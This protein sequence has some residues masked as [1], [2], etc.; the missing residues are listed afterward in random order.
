RRG[1]L[2]RVQLLRVSDEQHLLA[3]A[4]HHIITDGWSTGVLLEDLVV[5]YQAAAAGQ[6]S[7][8]PDLAVQYADF[9]VWQRGWLQGEVLERQI[10][11]WREQLAG[12]PALLELPTDFP[13]PAAQSF[14]GAM[15]QGTLPSELAEA[16][17]ELSRAEGTTLFM[18]LLAGYQALLARYSGQSDILVGVPIA[19]RLRPELASLIGFFVNT[20]VMRASLAEQ[21]TVRDLLAQVRHVALDAYAHQ[22]IPFEQLVEVLQPERTLSHTPIFQAAFTL[23][24]TP[25]PSVE[26]ADL[27]VSAMEEGDL[28]VAKFD[29]MLSV[30]E[31]AD[32]ELA[33]VVEYSTD[34][35][36]EATIRRMVEH[37]GRLLAGMAADPD[38]LVA[39]IDMLGDSERTT[40]L[41]TWNATS[42]PYSLVPVYRII[43]AQADRTPDAIALCVDSERYTYRQVLD[44]AYR[45]AHV[46]QARGVARGDRV[47][48]FLGRQRWLIPALLAVHAAGA[49]YVPLDPAY[50]TERLALMA[51]DADLRLIISESLLIDALPHTT[52]VL[53]VTSLRAELD[54]YPATDPEIM[55]TPDDLAYVIYTS[56]STGR[57]KGVAIP[58]RGL[59]SF[60]GWCA[61][62]YPAEDFAGLVASTSVCF[63]LSIFEI[64]APLACGGTIILV[65]DG[66][67]MPPADHQPPATLLNLIPSVVGELM[68]MG[69]LPPTV[70][71][72][73]LGGEAS[74]QPLIDEIYGRT[75]VQRIYNGYGPT[76]DTVYSTSML[77]QRGKTVLIGQ[78]IANTQAYILDTELRP[79][80]IGV[81]GDLYLGG[82]GQAWGYLGR[83]EL[84]AERFVPHP[85]SG[86]GGVPSGARLYT[87]GDL[88]RY[89]ADGMIEY[90]GRSDHQVKIRGFRIELG[91]IEA[92]LH[93]HPAIQQAVAACYSGPQSSADSRIAAYVVARPGQAVDSASLLAYLEQRLPRYMLPAAFIALEQL[94]HTP[95]GKVDRKA[96][97][98]PD[99]SAA[100][101][102]PYVAPQTPTEQLVARICAE[103]LDS[104][105][106]G[107]DDNFFLL[108]GHSLLATQ[109]L[110]QVQA[111]LG[112]EIPLRTFFESPTVGALS[113]AID[114]LLAGSDDEE[115]EDLD[116][117]LDLVEGFSD[118]EVAALLA[119]RLQTGLA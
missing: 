82:D 1:P 2:F 32:G 44:D 119:Q 57:P 88:A 16:L 116:D 112:I 53:D 33:F 63:D 60:I 95:N 62:Y 106:V 74:Q 39:A 76:E 29:L 36:E 103:L 43:A 28:G 46:L 111:Q 19:G 110:T 41:N 69:T 42:Q 4:L 12:A 114:V 49:A 100:L 96:L 83:A 85:L 22:D 117:L 17:R 64:F 7:T 84:T 90:L 68:Q 52:A 54:A 101:R 73:V 45:L 30:R 31:V 80:P 113:R 38:Q 75:G 55:V 91:E 72:I 5:L 118:E 11:Y 93:Q 35:F 89:R 115:E 6:A 78:P 98:T 65:E 8:L 108:G 10:G 97:P 37:Y 67:H 107:L 70:R 71:T 61:G 58:H 51:E 14:R 66:L 34:L 47:G 81:V 13:R 20:L 105:R 79:V 77:L 27:S 92:A 86:I 3:L 24:N 87:T 50:P 9:A 56:G 21:P 104:E 109:L 59:S 99:N 18:T 26:L 94:P 40:I 25:E 23:Q 15:V 102:A 48:I